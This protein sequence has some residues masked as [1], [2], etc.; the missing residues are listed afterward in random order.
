MCYCRAENTRWCSLFFIFICH[1]LRVGKGIV[2]FTGYLGNGRKDYPSN[3]FHGHCRS[4][5]HDAALPL[6]PENG[7]SNRICGLFESAIATEMGSHCPLLW[8]M[9]MYFLVRRQKH[10]HFY[11]YCEDF[12]VYLNHLLIYLRRTVRPTNADLV[13]VICIF[14]YTNMTASKVSC[15][16]CVYWQVSEGKVDKATGIFYKA[17]QNIPW[18]KVSYRQKRDISSGYFIF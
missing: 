6:L 14:E 2:N 5:C 15:L 17:L 8:R 7:L 10:S 12:C 3:F 9:Y 13:W 1:R 18:A 4:C 11:W 16:H